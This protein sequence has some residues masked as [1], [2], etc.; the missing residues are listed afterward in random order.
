MVNTNPAATPHIVS[1]PSSCAA[2][3]AWPRHSG[4][5]HSSS[6]HGSA[7]I[8]PDGMA[9]PLPADSCA[10]NGHNG[11]V[12]LCGYRRRIGNMVSMAVGQQ[13]VVDLRRTKFFGYLDLRDERINEEVR[14]LESG[15][16]R[17]MS[18]AM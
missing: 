7:Q 14:P 6:S 11:G 13:N 1:S 3:D 15:P 18:Q 5:P 2:D 12:V 10:H 8:H 4:P 16:A 9:T 17:S